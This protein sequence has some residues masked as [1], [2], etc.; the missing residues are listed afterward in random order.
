MKLAE[1]LGLRADCQKRIEQLKQHLTRN[2]RIQQG[3]SPAENPEDLINELERVAAD[4]AALIQRINRTNAATMIDE[5]TSLSDALAMR[6]VL[7]IR[8]RIYTALAEAASVTQGRYSRSEVKYRSTV[9]VK[10]IQQRADDLARE[11]RILD[12]R[13]QELNWRTEL[14]E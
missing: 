11:H 6:D 10:E 9:N 13:I 4:L 1:G 2:A 3:D 5:R 7:G 12:A 8:H 14:S